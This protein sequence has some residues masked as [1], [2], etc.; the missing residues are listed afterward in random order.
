L[1]ATAVAH[2]QVS[3][4]SVTREASQFGP[5]GIFIAFVADPE[6]NQIELIQ[7]ARR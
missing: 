6:G 3:L 4:N 1:T 5:S 2:A 7:P